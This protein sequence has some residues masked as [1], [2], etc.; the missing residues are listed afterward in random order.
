MVERTGKGGNG[1]GAGQREEGTIARGKDRFPRASTR[2][3][4]KNVAVVRERAVRRRRGGGVGRE[5]E[6]AAVVSTEAANAGL[7]LAGRRAEVGVGRRRVHSRDVRV[8]VGNLSRRLP[9]PVVARLRR[10]RSDLA[11]EE[12][13]AV[14]GVVGD[15]AASRGNVQAERRVRVEPAVRRLIG[16]LGRDH[17]ADVA[18]SFADTRAR[19]KL[20]IAI[21]AMMPMIATTISSSIRV[22]PFWFFLFKLDLP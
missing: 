18:D 9:G 3:L 14:R 16:R 17:R 21:A 11:V 22:K 8:D 2:E 19:S 5:A 15:A 1:R 10:Q 7:T 4:L 12:R 13:G 6:N 20:G